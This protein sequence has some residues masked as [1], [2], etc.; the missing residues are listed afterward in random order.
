MNQPS[1][2]GRNYASGLDKRLRE[3][4]VESATWGLL[5]LW[6]GAMMATTYDDTHDGFASVGAG[7][8]LLVSAVVQKA[9]RFQVGIILWAAGIA[10][11][12]TG[13]DDLLGTDDLPIFALIAMAFGAFLV[14]RGAAVKRFFL[15]VVGAFVALSGL[16]NV[17][18]RNDIP[19]TAILVVAFG[20]W[21]VARSLGGGRRR[22]GPPD[23]VA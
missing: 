18:D 20:L 8:I 12:L 15:V 2:G 11:L 23:R 9:L 7:V 16:D 1:G 5:I 19:T 21:L 4:K 17:L 3:I 13:L 14:V 10:L 22:G 6:I